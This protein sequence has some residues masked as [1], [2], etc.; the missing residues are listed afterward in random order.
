MVSFA[1]GR[2]E[3]PGR[4]LA[5]ARR[6][7]RHVDMASSATLPEQFARLWS[8]ARRFQRFLIVGAVGLAVN[9]GFLF[10]LAEWRSA[11]LLVASPIAI[12]VSMVVTFLLNEFWTWHDRGAGPLVHRVALYFPI[13]TVGLLINFLVLQALVDSTSLHYLAANLIGA[14]TAAIWNFGANHR[15][16]WRR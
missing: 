16:T 9:Q 14:A 7:S 6:K 3:S 8:L 1:G 15:I 2:P 4:L 11:P 12:F 10:V 13:N 5:L